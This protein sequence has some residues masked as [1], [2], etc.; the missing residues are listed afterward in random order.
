LC[1]CTAAGGA[2]GPPLR[3][4]E[5]ERAQCGRSRLAFQA[6]NRAPPR[7]EPQAGAAMRSSG[8]RAPGRR[9]EELG[10]PQGTLLGGKQ[11]KCGAI[12]AV[13]PPWAL[14][15]LR[16]EREQQGLH[17]SLQHMIAQAARRPCR[18][19]GFVRRCWRGFSE[20][21]K[22]LA[23]AAPLAAS[24]SSISSM[25]QRHGWLAVGEASEGCGPAAGRQRRQRM[26]GH[27]RQAARGRDYWVSL[28][29]GTKP[30]LGQAGGRQC[31]A[32]EWKALGTRVE[33][34][35][36]SRGYLGRLM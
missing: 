4:R 6:V 35:G 18:A 2:Q 5:P 3:G 19:M 28:H 23:G 36:C 21:R 16:V 15:A 25:K 22:L 30:G 17:P 34:G 7:S 29:T 1:A 32:R 24:H 8:R 14:A 11:R 13:A 10:F 26:Q 9:S 20:T 27:C 12:S 31:V 33:G